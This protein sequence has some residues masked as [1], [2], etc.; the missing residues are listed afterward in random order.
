MSARTV[1]TQAELSEII[2]L[3]DKIK[4]PSCRV[5]REVDRWG[6]PVGGES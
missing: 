3:G 2:P 4:A 5:V 6:D 1:S